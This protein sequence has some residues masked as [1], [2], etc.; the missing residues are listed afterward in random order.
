MAYVNLFVAYIKITVISFRLSLKNH[1]LGFFGFMFNIH[2]L[3]Y[4]A[5]A[6]RQFC[7]PALDRDSIKLNHLHIK[8]SL[9]WYH[10]V[11]QKDPI[12]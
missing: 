7:S 6:L 11:K 4:W 8:E 5:K 3:Q 9:I 2:D 1:N 10:S 12:N